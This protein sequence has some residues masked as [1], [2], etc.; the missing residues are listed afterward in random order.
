MEVESVDQKKHI[1]NCT[2]LNAMPNA[3]LFYGTCGPGHIIQFRTPGH[4][5]LEIEQWSSPSLY[6]NKQ[7][8]YCRLYITYVFMDFDYCESKTLRYL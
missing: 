5:L 7:N 8:K 6:S 4:I 1:T 3:L 2:H